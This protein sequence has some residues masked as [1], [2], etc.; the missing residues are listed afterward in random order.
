MINKREI[1]GR[2]GLIVRRLLASALDVVLLTLLVGLLTMGVAWVIVQVKGVPN[3]LQLAIM[4][5]HVA[6]DRRVYAWYQTTAQ[7]IA[8]F[9]LAAFPAIWWL[10]D[11]TFSWRAIRSTPGKWL[12]CLETA[13]WRNRSPRLGEAALRSALKMATFLS[14]LLLGKLAL[15]AIA[16]LALLAIPTLTSRAQF[17]HDLLPGTIVR[18]RRTWLA[19]FTRQHQGAEA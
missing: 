7:S 1:P 11:M 3:D 17:L 19:W 18:S 8:P 6:P 9:A 5:H 14:L 15:L 4:F 10:Y 16:L 12:L 13:S 2:V